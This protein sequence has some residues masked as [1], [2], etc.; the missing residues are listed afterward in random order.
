MPLNALILLD[1]NIILQLVR[2]NKMSQQLESDYR[3]ITRPNS[4]LISYVTVGELYALSLKL[5]WGSEK[6]ARLNE[7][8]DDLVIIN[9]NKPNIVE[10]YARI[11]YFSEKVMKP[12]RPLGQNDMWIAATAKTVGAWLM[13]TDND[14]DH[15]HPK[16]LQRILIDAKTGETIDGMF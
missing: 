2:N 12:A 16:Y 6:I 10:N 13:T 15:L 8:L 4:N 1:T 9:I 14:F 5:G 7:I 3:L 11:N